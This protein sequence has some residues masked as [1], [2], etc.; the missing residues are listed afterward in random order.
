MVRK[1]I[2][3]L[4]SKEITFPIS[5]CAS[6]LD[7]SADRTK[8]FRLYPLPMD[9]C[10]RAGEEVRHIRDVREGSARRLA[11]SDDCKAA[12]PPSRYEPW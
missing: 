11:G 2:F 1:D 3:R 5:T 4:A 7:T 9:R 8:L 10:I 6:L 12:Y